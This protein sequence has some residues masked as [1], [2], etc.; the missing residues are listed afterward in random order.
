MSTIDEQIAALTEEMGLEIDD[1]P[2]EPKPPTEPDDKTKTLEE[3][4]EQ[5]QTS[6]KSGEVLSQLLQDPDFATL[7]ALKQQGK[8][9]K[10]A[11]ATQQVQ[12]PTQQTSKVEEIDWESA[13]P[14]QI[15]DYTRRKTLEDVKAVLPEVLKAHMT[16][17][18]EQLQQVSSFV[19]EQVQKTAQQQ[20]AEARKKYADFDELVPYMRQIHQVNPGLSAEELYLLAATRLGRSPTP[21]RELETERPGSVSGRPPLRATRKTPLEPG[22]SGFRRALDESLSRL[23]LKDLG[24]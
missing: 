15:A 2:K 17:I 21:R 18:Q 24:V 7:L 22:I 10:I 14:Q 6:N 13:T 19:G 1:K 23:D 16:P 8:Q 4:L 11:D 5:L 9:V 20:V 12:E 3:K